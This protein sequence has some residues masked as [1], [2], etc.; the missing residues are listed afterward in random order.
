MA[1][2]YVATQIQENNRLV[3]THEE[4][5]CILRSTTDCKQIL[6]I[7]ELAMSIIADGHMRPHFPHI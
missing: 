7:V 4:I 3:R 5:V 2:I 6:Q 1:A